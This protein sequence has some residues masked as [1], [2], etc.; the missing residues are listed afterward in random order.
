MS[1]F[2][3]TKALNIHSIKNLVFIQIILLLINGVFLII[4]ISNLIISWFEW[5]QIE[6]NVF[7]T[8]IFLNLVDLIPIA[9]YFYAICK[10]EW[11]QSLISWYLMLSSL[12][13]L[14]DVLITSMEA[15]EYMSDKVMIAMLFQYIYIGTT[16]L[17]VVL[18]HKH[19]KRIKTSNIHLEQEL[20]K[21]K[22]LAQA[23]TVNREMNRSDHQTKS[24]R[25][26]SFKDDD[27]IDFSQ[28][29][30]QL[31]KLEARVK[32]IGRYATLKTNKNDKTV[33]TV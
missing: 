21:S 24:N 22:R 13:I 15:Y 32:R 7:K 9:V 6:I 17:A 3:R 26:D 28:A 33:K 5:S 27:S 23:D 20:S 14:S 11:K 8:I 30:E 18:I 4:F 10:K 19:L 1:S 29:F 31:D 12:W 25:T 16:F 2:K